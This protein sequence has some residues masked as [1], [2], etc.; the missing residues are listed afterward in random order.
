MWDGSRRRAALGSIAGTFLT[1]FVLVSAFGTRWI[2]A[3]VAV[4]M[5]L[6]AVAVRPPW[7][8]GRVFEPR[9]AARGDHRRRRGLAQQLREGEQLLL[10]PPR[11]R[12]RRDDHGERHDPGRRLH[13]SALPRPPPARR[14]QPPASDQAL[15][16]DYERLYA[17]SIDTA[18][19]A[20]K[21]RRRLL[22]SAA[23]RTRFRGT[24]NMSIAG[25]SSSRRSTP[26]SRRSRALASG[27]AN[28]HGYEI[29][30]ERRAAR[31]ARTAAGRSLR[32]R[33]RRR[34]Q[35]LRGSVP[36]HDSAVQRVVAQHLKPD[37]LYLLNVIDGVHY[38]FAR[39]EVRTLRTTFPY[40]GLMSPPDFWP[41][42]ANNRPTYVLVAAKTTPARP[43]PIDAPAR[44]G[45]VRRARAQRRPHGRP[46][47]GRSA[48]RARLQ[49][50]APRL[51]ATQPTRRIWPVVASRSASPADGS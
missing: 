29:H 31:A 28:R 9:L 40:V 39:S 44:A 17:R 3:G 27:S 48:A 41:P 46:R 33:P 12:Q 13:P 26:R 49:P 7:L 1:G 5:L 4:T 16:Y 36:A 22:A 47:A 37:G 34:V 2:V 10:H 25:E 35:R 15:Y 32:F 20:R 6:L 42:S 8:G 18:P 23:A 43:L 14:E 50:G 19:S 51:T 24:S 11:G 21:P 30:N 45:F 38:D